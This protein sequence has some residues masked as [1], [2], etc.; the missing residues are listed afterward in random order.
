MVIRSERLPAPGETVLGGRF[1]SAA[2]GKGANQAVAA[3]RAGASVAFVAKIGR[4]AFGEQALD[5][6]RNEGLDVRWV[7]RDRDLPSGVALILVDSKG[8]NLISVAPGANAALSEEDVRNSREA[9]AGCDCL[10]LQLEIPLP[11]VTEAVRIAVE[12]KR[13]R[14]ILNPSP[15]PK[16]SLPHALL[17]RVDVLLPNAVELAMLSGQ[18]KDPEKGAR[19][20]LDAGVGAVVVTL[21][22]KGAIVVEKAATTEIP[23]FPAKPV[24]TVGAGDCFA[25]ALAVAL[26]E[27]ATLP[28]AA[29]FATAAASI[30]VERPGA[31]PSLPSR[32]EILRRE[33]S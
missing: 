10:L 26:S 9:I 8:E 24:D 4:D 28:D 27:G 19:R 20:L 25:G 31:Q 12:S 23:A 3:A 29:R 7:F 16:E 32:E 6:F 5:G 33:R 11:A 30:A 17:S 1:Y 21:G 14:V 13:T 2:G 18:A 22:K 15:A